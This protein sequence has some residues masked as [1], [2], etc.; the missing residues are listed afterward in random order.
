MIINK[1]EKADICILNI[2]D[3]IQGISLGKKIKEKF[4]TIYLVYLS[5]NEH[6]CIEAINKVHAFSFLCRPI[7]QEILQNQILDILNFFPYKSLTK[8]FYNVTDNE[9]RKYAL[10]KLKLEDILYLNISNDSG[11]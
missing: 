4:P 11:K 9:S 3:Q 2:S 10:I 8:I 7:N 1:V 6:A 5:S